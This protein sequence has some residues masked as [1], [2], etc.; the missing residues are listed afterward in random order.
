[1]TESANEADLGP[2]RSE[3]VGARGGEAEH[4]PSPT[5]WREER[6]NT[7]TDRQHRNRLP[8]TSRVWFFPTLIL[9]M[10]IISRAC[11]VEMS[12]KPRPA[13]PSNEQVCLAKYDECVML[14]EAG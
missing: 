14:C 10:P 1:H 6:S 12:S 8:L 4:D 5:R 13:A 11:M 3:G 7:M 9:L 2:E